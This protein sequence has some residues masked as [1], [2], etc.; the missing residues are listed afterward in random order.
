MEE[1]IKDYE[2]ILL[3]ELPEDEHDCI[4]TELVT[5]IFLCAINFS[6]NIV[7]H[8]PRNSSAD[9]NSCFKILIEMINHLIHDSDDTRRVFEPNLMYL[10]K[11]EDIVTSK[12]YKIF[13]ME[14]CMR[15][16]QLFELNCEKS[17]EEGLWIPSL[18]GKMVRLKLHKSIRRAAIHLVSIKAEYLASTEETKKLL[19]AKNDIDLVTLTLEVGLNE[20]ELITKGLEHEWKLFINN[21]SYTEDNII[22]FL[23]F[24]A[25][26]QEIQL[27]WFDD[28]LLFDKWTNYIKKYN[29]VKISKETFK[30]LIELFSVTTEEA[31]SWSVQ[32]PFIKFGHGYALWVHYFKSMHPNLLLIVMWTKKHSDLWNN[33]LGGQFAKVASYIKGE[34]DDYEGIFI[35]TEKKRKGI[36]DIDLAIY[37]SVHD[38]IVICEIKSV[39]DK[40]RTNY[41]LNNYINQRVNFDKANKQ[42]KKNYD[43]IESGIW[44]MQ[45]IFS[46]RIHKPRNITKIIIT[47]WDIIN[48]NVGTEDEEN[49]TCNIAVFKY[50]YNKSK[51]NIPKFIETIKELSKIYCP[52]KLVVNST[53]NGDEKI[54]FI[55]E[56]QT[57]ILPAQIN[58]SKMNLSIDTMNEIENMAKFPDDWENQIRKSNDNT[59]SW[60]FYDD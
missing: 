52:A 41:Q 1:Y 9:H 58:I 48:P 11:V 45:E 8:V 46:H 34:L 24:I 60:Y 21:F 17:I 43:A 27:I 2:K 19:S 25:Y 56:I 3:T 49:I 28:D 42:L 29:Q 37:D 4:Y 15:F 31:D 54:E 55:K 6:E 40:F 35:V 36:G 32:S 59:D 51:G 38:H 57:D 33:T 53:Y 5:M 7:S 13:E 12:V 10:S 20:L 26:L 39:F 47:W 14:F 18:K 50:L 23:G 16:N 44:S 30:E 22:S